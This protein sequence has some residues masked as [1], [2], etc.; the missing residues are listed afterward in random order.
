VVD[1]A[2]PA[3]RSVFPYEECIISYSY[4]LIEIP[5][6]RQRPRQRLKASQCYR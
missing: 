4:V 6:F 5:H 2:I 1:P 3:R